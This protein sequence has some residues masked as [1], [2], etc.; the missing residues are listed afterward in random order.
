MK[1]F[2]MFFG[3]SIA[4]MLFFFV[5]R[6]AIVAFIAAAIMSIIYAVFRR[7]KDFVTY[8]SYGE[9]YMKR[10]RFDSSLANNWNQQVEPLFHT[11]PTQHR[12]QNQATRYIQTI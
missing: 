12:S 6:I 3:L 1:P 5:A 8:D 11:A 4:F 9:P 7:V 2:K 10:Q